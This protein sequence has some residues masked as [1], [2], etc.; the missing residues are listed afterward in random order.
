MATLTCL[1][2][3]LAQLPCTALQQAQRQASTRRIDITSPEFCKSKSWC[4]AQ[5]SASSLQVSVAKLILSSVCNGGAGAGSLSS[6]DAAGLR[7]GSPASC[8]IGKFEKK[9]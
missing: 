7:N 9:T 8:L 5:R 6:R 1:F 4:R 3:F 2:F